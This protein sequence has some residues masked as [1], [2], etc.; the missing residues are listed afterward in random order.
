MR[1][2]NTLLVANSGDGTISTLRL[3]A[4]EGVLKPIATSAVG[5]GCNTFAFDPD[6]NLVYASIKGEPPWVV[7]LAFE[8]GSGQLREVSRRPVHFSMSYLALGHEGS[9]LLGASY[10]GGYGAVWPIEEGALGEPQAHVEF[11]NLHCLVSVKDRAY[12]VSLGED[13]IAAFRL[14]DC[15][16]LS[17]LDPPVVATPKGSGPRHLIVSAAHAYVVTEYSGEVVR[18]D[19]AQDGTLQR[20]ESVRID[21]PSAG[22]GHSRMGADPREQNLMWGA[23]VHLAGRWLL[24]SERTASTIATVALHD[25]RLGEVTSITHVEEQPRGFAV[26]PCGKFVVSVGERS[27]KAAL[28]RVQDDGSLTLVHRAPVG[29]KANWV[30]FV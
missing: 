13:L 28:L 30:R 5:E 16:T 22:L 24:A 20:A 9:L 1:P 4:H 7:T 23:D 26:S 11:E 10:G 14:G 8:R 25:G 12:A 29:E 21:D 18:C 17:P 2:V 15:G 3:D 19:V 27:T 6:R